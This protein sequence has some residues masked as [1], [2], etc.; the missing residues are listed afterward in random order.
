MENILIL[1]RAKWIDE[2]EKINKN[3]CNSESGN[4]ISKS[5]NKIVPDSVT[6]MTYTN[7]TFVEAK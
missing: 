5:M 3:Y 2:G 4:V 6:V 7:D 1:S